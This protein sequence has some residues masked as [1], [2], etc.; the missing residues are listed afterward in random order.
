VSVFI[1]NLIDLT[2]DAASILRISNHTRIPAEVVKAAR[3]RCDVHKARIP[4]QAMPLAGRS[5]L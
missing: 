5:P 4:K 2:E 1:G 3:H